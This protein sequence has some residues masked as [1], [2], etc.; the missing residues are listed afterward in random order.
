MS[1]PF[2]VAGRRWLSEQVPPEDER[3]TLD[4]ALRQIDFLTEEVTKIER[5]LAQFALDSPQTKR[6]MTVPGV[7][8]ITAVAFLAQVDEIGRFAD[9]RQLSAAQ[10]EA[11]ES[12]YRRNVAD[13]QTPTATTSQ[14]DHR[15][16]LTFIRPRLIS[17]NAS[18]SSA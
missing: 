14:E 6:L 15:E 5:D 13:W 17:F 10:P 2:G 3:D 4:A 7:G 1:D 8:L 11:A 9:P 16:D 12:A 18:M